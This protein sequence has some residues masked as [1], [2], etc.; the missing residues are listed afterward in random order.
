MFVRKNN[1]QHTLSLEKKK[2]S[3][4]IEKRCLRF[5][6]RTAPPPGSAAPPVA[7]VHWCDL[8]SG[9]PT[10]LFRPGPACVVGNKMA[11]WY[12]PTYV[13]TLKDSF[14]LCNRRYFV[15]VLYIFGFLAAPSWIRL[16]NE[17]RLGSRLHI[18]S[19]QPPQHL[20]TPLDPSGGRRARSQALARHVR[21]A[22]RRVRTTKAPFFLG[23]QSY[24]T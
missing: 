11:S 16:C 19:L 21:Y 2:V 14:K 10:R 6:P 18:P 1:T 15:S 22:G 12:Y 7:S 4:S 24:R 13:L 20:E 8:T 3:S 17:C 23:L 9:R 5:P